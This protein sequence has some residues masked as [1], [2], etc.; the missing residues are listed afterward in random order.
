ML[1]LLVNLSTVAILGPV[2]IRSFGAISYQVFVFA[3]LTIGLPIRSLVLHIDMNQFLLGGALISSDDLE[4]ADAIGA[5]SIFGYTLVIL[6]LKQRRRPHPDGTTTNLFKHN[7]LLLFSLALLILVAQITLSLNYSSGDLSSLEVLSQRSIVSGSAIVLAINLSPIVLTLVIANIL[8]SSRSGSHVAVVGAWLLLFI[9]LGWLALLSGRATAAIALWSLILAMKY[10][11]KAKVNAL[12]VSSAGV[13]VALV[14]IAGLALRKASQQNIDVTASVAL[15]LGDVLN[16]LSEALPSVD[17]FLVGILYYTRSG[18]DFG[19]HILDA[20]VILVPRDIWP[21]K[22]IL[23]PQKI[24]TALT[25]YDKSGLP[26]GFL[27]EGYI[28][29]GIVGTA[30]STAI[31]GFFAHFFQ[32]VLERVQGRNMIVA[33]WAI[34]IMSSILAEYVRVGP[35][36]ALSTLIIDLGLF[37]IVYL[38]AKLTPKRPLRKNVGYFPQANSSGETHGL[39]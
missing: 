31:L 17:H 21:D 20:L 7:Q 39:S 5:A 28:A 23:M 24:A 36:G 33:T 11:G 25:R 38:A 29:A 35:Q 30:L 8:V 18:F 16:S 14:T 4:F 34:V 27:G 37:P 26:A 2:V 6:A 10:I 1:T 9:A 15:S 22:P 32:R 3:L 12:H 13:L 19:A